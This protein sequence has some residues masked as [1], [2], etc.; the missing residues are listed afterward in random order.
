MVSTHGGESVYERRGG[1][2]YRRRVGSRGLGARRI[3]VVVERG[4]KEGRVERR[5]ANKNRDE[6]ASVDIRRR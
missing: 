4:R 3:F 5:A 6:G 2:S 1:V